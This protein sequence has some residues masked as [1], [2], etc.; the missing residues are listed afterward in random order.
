MNQ[1]MTSIAA[2]NTIN[3]GNNLAGEKLA[4]PISCATIMIM[5]EQT[6]AVYDAALNRLMKAILHGSR[7]TERL[8]NLDGSVL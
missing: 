8:E 3:V 4:G 5:A 1:N 6:E 7:S 2:Q